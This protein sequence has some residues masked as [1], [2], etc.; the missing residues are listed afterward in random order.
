[1]NTDKNIRL[2]KVRPLPQEREKLLPRLWKY[3]RLDWPSNRSQINMRV[4]KKSSPG[5]EDLG[6]GVFIQ[7]LFFTM[8]RS[9]HL[10]ST[11]HPLIR[12]STHL[13]PKDDDECQEF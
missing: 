12:Q 5:G 8:K 10:W 6:E 7:T 11:K 13:L 3:K 2:W 9:R 1:M 4:S